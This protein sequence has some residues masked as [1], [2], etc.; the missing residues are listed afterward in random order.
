MERTFAFI[1]PDAVRNGSVDG[2]KSIIKSN[3]F[4]IVKEMETTL[5][6]EQA[7]KFYAEHNGK[8]FYDNLVQFMTS[9][10]AVAMVLQ[11]DGAIQAWRDLMGPTNTENAK[12][13]APNSLRAQFGTDGTQNATHGSDSPASAAR[14]ISLIFPDVAPTTS[15][16]T[17][18]DVKQYLESL[19]VPT[20]TKALTEMCLIKPD[21]PFR[22]LAGFM[23][24]NNPRGSTKL[25]WTDVVVGKLTK[26]DYFGE[27]AL[28]TNKP[29]QATVKAVDDCVLLSMDRDAF[30][31]LCGPLF[32]ILKRNM[33]AYQQYGLPVQDDLTDLVQE[34][35]EEEE[36]EEPEPE[37]EPEPTAVSTRTR[38]RRSNVFVAPIVMDAPWEPPV[39]D[40]TEEQKA[41]VS[42]LL[43]KS[44]MLRHLDDSAQRTVINALQGK[45]VSAGTNIITQGEEGDLF[46]IL[47]SG[48]AKVFVKK[49]DE[50]PK[51]VHT[52]ADGDT[53]GELAL[54]HG[55]PRAATV[56][57]DTDCEL[58]GLDRDTF[59][60]IMMTS[61]LSEQ[62]KR[63][64]FLGNVPLLATLDKF[65]RFRIAEAMHEEKV[66]AGQAIIKEGETGDK[67]F[68]IKSGTAVAT[69]NVAKI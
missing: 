33:E 68:I 46:Y 30:Q 64:A 21:D 45:T 24:E 12:Q 53:F 49:G 11:K 38:A 55:E 26:G 58:W 40:K 15:N 54:L 66:P 9:G 67:F 23:L 42:L 16:M 22:W 65:E 35:E 25:E 56:V 60:R 69:K 39:F 51:Q 43:Q 59:R 20:L 52:Y 32:D 28:L 4:T 17:A 6:A 31:R 13:S 61:G 41:A 62:N 5:S 36:E 44:I 27:I 1:K 57:A 10:P 3:G 14:E 29:R 48:K 19:V 47:S 7:G 18:E 63:E 2:I 37:P 34:D 8:P 50:E